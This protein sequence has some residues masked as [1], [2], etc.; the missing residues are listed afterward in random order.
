MITVRF[1]YFFFFGSKSL[2]LGE[3]NGMERKGLQGSDRTRGTCS[4]A[5][6]TTDV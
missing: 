6:G 4:V 5:I 3:L 2:K 1:T